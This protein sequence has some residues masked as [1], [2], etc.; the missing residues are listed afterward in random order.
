MNDICG[1]DW[2][3]GG[4]DHGDPGTILCILDFDLVSSYFLLSLPVIMSSK[5]KMGCNFQLRNY[6]RVYCFIFLVIGLHIISW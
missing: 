6:V 1:V 3:Y 4:G 5:A 2:I